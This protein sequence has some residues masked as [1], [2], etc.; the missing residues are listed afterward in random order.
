MHILYVAVDIIHSIIIR[1]HTPPT[2]EYP[3]DC[4]GC[5][6]YTYIWTYM[7]TYEHIYIHM[8]TYTYMWTHIHTCEHIY[9]HINIYTYI[10]ITRYHQNTTYYSEREYCLLVLL[11]S[12]ICHIILY[13]SHHQ[14]KRESD[15]YWYSF[16][17]LYISYHIL[18]TIHDITTLRTLLIMVLYG[19]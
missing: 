7:H 8:N 6:L 19:K 10:Y 15:V 2:S 17:P 3:R 5:L 12:L 13:M 16:S 1:P 4:P 14:P 18:Y 11:Q 9:I